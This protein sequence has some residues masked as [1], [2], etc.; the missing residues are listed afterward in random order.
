[1]PRSEISDHVEI[2]G[3]GSLDWVGRV[4]EDE[5]VEKGSTGVSWSWASETRHLLDWAISVHS[6]AGL[7]S[8]STHDVMLKLFSGLDL[9][10]RRC[11]EERAQPGGATPMTLT[12]KDF[13]MEGTYHLQGASD[14]SACL[15]ALRRM[16]ESLADA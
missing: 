6:D 2:V 15:L 16:K 10:V 14:L 11:T 12:G 3:V 5:I 8:T 9:L 4:E 1:M 13:M 7:V